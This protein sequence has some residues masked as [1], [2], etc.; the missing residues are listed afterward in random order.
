[1]LYMLKISRKMVSVETQV[2][3]PGVMRP[4][5]STQPCL[6]PAV[7]CQ[8]IWATSA[9]TSAVPS[10]PQSV[11]L[12]PVI[13]S[14]ARAE[15]GP[16]AGPSW[17]NRSLA[18][19]LPVPPSLLLFV[20]L[21]DSH[22]NPEPSVCCRWLSFCCSDLSWASRGNRVSS[23]ENEQREAP[24]IQHG[25]HLP[26]PSPKDHRLGPGGRARSPHSK[27]QPYKSFASGP[28]EGWRHLQSVSNP[29]PM[30]D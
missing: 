11:A 20:P 3:G 6:S 24:A 26:T 10:H 19:H 28:Q 17:T 4:G 12:F 8:A 22:P 9:E 1:M 25:S 5:L 30:G 21:L 23:F 27:S 18:V 29:G 7:R 15:H 13:N 14:W 16:R 2:L